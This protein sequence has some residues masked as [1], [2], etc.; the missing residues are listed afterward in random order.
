MKQINAAI[1]VRV[2]TLDQK[3]EGTSIESQ[4]KYSL[5]YAVELNYLVN[6]DHIFQDVMSGAE[7]FNR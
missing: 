3:E 2:S 6:P 4:I 1:Y 5:E 7:Y